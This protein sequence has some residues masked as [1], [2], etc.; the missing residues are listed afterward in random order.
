[1]TFSLSY[2]YSFFELVFLFINLFLLRV[3]FSSSVKI[4]SINFSDKAENFYDS[5]KSP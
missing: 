2:S 4:D 3:N 5:S 1:M